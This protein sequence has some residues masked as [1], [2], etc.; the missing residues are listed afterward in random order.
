MTA[1]RT[2][3][4]LDS[5]ILSYISSHEKPTSAREAEKVDNGE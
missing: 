1:M 4:L 5:Y 3:D 2:A